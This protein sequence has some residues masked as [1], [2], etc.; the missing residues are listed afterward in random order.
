LTPNTDQRS[1][2]GC[3]Q[4][5]EGTQSTLS[6]CCGMI[7]GIVSALIVVLIILKDWFLPEA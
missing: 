5:N 7:C 2:G 6:H 3:L 1:D 4:S